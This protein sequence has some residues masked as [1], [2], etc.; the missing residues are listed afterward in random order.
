M[1]DIAVL[2][3]KPALILILASLLIVIVLTTIAVS[4][5]RSTIETDLLQ[6]TRQALTQANLPSKNLSISGRDI[7]LNGT[8]NDQSEAEHIMHVASEVNGVRNVENNLTIDPNTPVETT[9]ETDTTPVAKLK[10]PATMVDGVYQP[11]KAQRIEK[12]DLSNIQ[13][14]YAKSDLNPE[15]KASLD[16]VAPLLRVDP[17][18]IIEISAHTEAHG[19]ALGSMA[20]SQARAD[21]MRT[22]LIAKGVLPEQV[23]ANGYGATRPIVKPASDLKNRRAE[24]VVLSKEEN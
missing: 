7:M 16:K 13:F 22:Y 20:V 15:A 10:S 6:R 3:R 23:I 12:L 14:E 8:A 4:W 1:P 24:I 9:T 21:A 11:S 2:K 17:K 5:K 19:S 18:L